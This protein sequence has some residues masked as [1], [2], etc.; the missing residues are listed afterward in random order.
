LAQTGPLATT[1]A[2]LSGQPPL[3][4]GTEIAVQFPQALVL[5]TTE[6]VSAIGVPS[7]VAKWT[8]SSWEILRPGVI[9][10]ENLANRNNIKSA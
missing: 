8:G 7:T 9:K 10:L 6:E 3:L 4:T 2:N 5:T 1:S